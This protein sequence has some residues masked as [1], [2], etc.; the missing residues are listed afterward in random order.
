M[1]IEKHEKQTTRKEKET[2]CE[3]KQRAKGESERREESKRSVEKRERKTQ[4][5]DI[6]KLSTAP[7]LSER[8]KAHV[9]A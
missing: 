2:Y 6:I 5:N 4:M 3:R 8:R 9:Q 1:S 7:F